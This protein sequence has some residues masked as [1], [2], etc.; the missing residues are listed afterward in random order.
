MWLM[1]GKNGRKGDWSSTKYLK[2]FKEEILKHFGR[3]DEK[4]VWI[5][6]CE[7]YEKQKRGRGNRSKRGRKD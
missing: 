5:D 6:I 4:N 3:K 2:L 1:R 7:G